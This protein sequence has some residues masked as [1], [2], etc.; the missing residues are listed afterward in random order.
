MKTHRLIISAMSAAAALG[1]AGVCA[2]AE[3]AQS[4]SAFTARDAF[5]PD[6]NQWGPQVGRRSLQWDSK[7]GHWGLKLDLNQAVGR[8]LSST[9][10]DV[11]AGAY[12][13]VTPSFSVGG[14]V[15]IGTVRNDQQSVIPADKPPQVRLEGAFKF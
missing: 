10:R 14:A 15:S 3:T 13:K 9:D 12:F 4:Q 11:Q 2:H 6:L 5:A 7:K 1:A 8:P